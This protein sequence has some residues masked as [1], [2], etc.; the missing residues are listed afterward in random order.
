MSIDYTLLLG[1]RDGSAQDL[2]VRLPDAL[3][4]LLGVAANGYGVFVQ[5]GLV[6]TTRIFGTTS[7]DARSTA[8]AELRFGFVPTADVGFSPDTQVDDD[9]YRAAVARM[10]ETAVALAV[11]LGARAVLVLNGELLVLRVG[12]GTIELNSGWS[13]WST[14]GL[15]DALTGRLS[16]WFGA[17]VAEAVRLAP[18]DSP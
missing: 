4:R 6:T 10:V 16:A 14:W 12:D 17:P 5:P 8:L 18:L 7:T 3:A 2:A 13:G 1:A 15:A 9:L 11:V